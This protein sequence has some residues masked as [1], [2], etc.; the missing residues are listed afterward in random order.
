M[1]VVNKAVC[2]VECV[3]A[4]E[5]VEHFLLQCPHSDLCKKII[6]TCSSLGVPPEI[7]LLSD[8]RM[9]DLIYI[10]ETSTVKCDRQWYK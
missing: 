4:V 2:H 9:L 3:T 5:T 10:L 1:N 8:N 7:N 6:S